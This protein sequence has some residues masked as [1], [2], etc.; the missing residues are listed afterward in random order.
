MLIFII[1]AKLFLVA[2]HPAEPPPHWQEYQYKIVYPPA[3]TTRWES[4]SPIKKVGCIYY[5][6]V[7][8]SIGQ[9]S[10]K[11]WFPKRWNFRPPME[12]T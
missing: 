5:Y 1:F 2:K 9:P 4:T 6:F 12:P 8:N 7:K 3:N 10:G 11:K